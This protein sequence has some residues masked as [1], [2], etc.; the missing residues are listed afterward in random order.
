MTER[1]KAI[2]AETGRSRRPTGSRIVSARSSSMTAHMWF[3]WITDFGLRRQ[4]VRRRRVERALAGDFRS[5]RT[6]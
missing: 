1:G 5:A 2:S 4:G 3:R 6:S